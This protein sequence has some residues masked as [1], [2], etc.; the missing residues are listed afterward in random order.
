VTLS[1][2][3]PSSE[4]WALA[5]GE[6]ER[7]KKDCRVICCRKRKKA[8]GQLNPQQKPGK[9]ETVVDDP[10]RLALREWM[11]GMSHVIR[12]TR[13]K[14]TAHSKTPI[15]RDSRHAHC[16]R[17]TL[18]LD[19]DQMGQKLETGTLGDQ[20]RKQLDALQLPQMDHSE[21]PPQLERIGT[22]GTAAGAGRHV[23]EGT[24]DN[25]FVPF[26]ELEH[27]DLQLK[28]FLVLKFHVQAFHEPAEELHVLVVRIQQSVVE[29]IRGRRAVE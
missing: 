23:A 16:D 6:A 28:T 26:A 20:R 12:L 22:V 2:E 10:T 17:Q 15:P 1:D 7:G 13:V 24:A 18:F 21:I 19:R 8:S 14:A 9:H 27:L 5:L 29:G 4:E 3:E 25:P 11:V